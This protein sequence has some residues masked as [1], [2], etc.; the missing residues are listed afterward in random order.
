MAWRA[1][2]NQNKVK[3]ENK[4]KFVMENLF[5]GHRDNHICSKPRE[6]CDLREF[7]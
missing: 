2:I 6:R 1:F 4:K 5:I 3:K 7:D